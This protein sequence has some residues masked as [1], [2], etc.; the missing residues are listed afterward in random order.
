M[1]GIMT[2]EEVHEMAQA[3]ADELNLRLDTMTPEERALT[4]KAL[5]TWHGVAGGF[6][7]EKEDEKR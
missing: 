3:I 2:R 4:V 5:E 7:T 6:P 1:S